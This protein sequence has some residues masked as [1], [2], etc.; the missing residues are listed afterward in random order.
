MPYQ[1]LGVY[2]TCL[3]YRTCRRSCIGALAQGGYSR[4]GIS[5]YTLCQCRTSRSDSI[6]H[7]GAY[8][9]PIPEMTSRSIRYVSAGHGVASA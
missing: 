7:L 1:A 3:Q 6:G 9:M 5:I 8:T 2:K 4:A